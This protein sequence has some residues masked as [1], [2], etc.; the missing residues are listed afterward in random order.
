[1][2]LLVARPGWR[3]G[4]RRGEVEAHGPNGEHLRVPLVEVDMIL[5]STRAASVSARL[6][7]E[8]ARAGIPVY[9]VDSRGDAVAVL[10]P[11]PSYKGGDKVLAQA[12]WRLDEELQLRAA[13]W[14]VEYKLRARVKL[15]RLIA[16]SRAPWV[17]DV[18]Y[19][20][21]GMVAALWEAGSVRELMGLEAAAGHLYWPSF[22]EAVGMEGFTGRKPRGGDPWNSLLDYVYSLLTGVAHRS[23]VL[24]GLN[25]YIGY[26][27]VDKHGRPSLS[28]DFVEPYRWMGE[29][30]AYRVASSGR[31]P[32]V[33]MD[34]RLTHESRRLILEVWKLLVSQGPPGIRVPVEKLLLN[35]AWRLGDS[36]VR[37][38]DWAPTLPPY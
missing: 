1:L 17:R 16:K 13:R 15:L 30:V 27:H 6:L 10:T 23:L 14:F 5:V 34:G 9:I 35:D 4:L 18:A 2:R 37:G 25:P 26:L 11:S 29:W 33:G 22:A 38:E 24:V 7:T 21:E 20:L 32:E 36:L 3:L 19:R 12:R 8:A 31:P 28:L